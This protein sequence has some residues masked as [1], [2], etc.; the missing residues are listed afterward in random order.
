VTVFD[1]GTFPL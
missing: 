1:Q